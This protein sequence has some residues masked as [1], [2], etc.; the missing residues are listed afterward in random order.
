[1][2]LHLG[3]GQRYLEGYVNIDFPNDHHSVGSVKADIYQDI[4]SLSYP[5][6]TIDEI[7]SHHVFEHFDRATA[8]ALLCRWRNWLV[9]GGLLRIETPDLM[10]SSM[11]LINP[12]LPYS[13]KE[14]V[15]RHLFG[16]HEADW[17]MH[18]DGWYKSKFEYYLSNLQFEQIR[19][20]TN[21]WGVLRNLE[22]YAVKNCQE[23]SHSQYQTISKRILQNSTVRVHTKDKYKP[24]GSELK[25]LQYWLK[26]WKTIYVGNKQ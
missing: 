12:L 14:Q 25:M 22:V 17:A 24:E 19:F 15:T 10:A 8:L 3:C 5:D 13:D 23:L 16:S 11:L 21:K 7:R 4:T 6:K 18:W 2:K 20:K 1:M 9:P 26:K